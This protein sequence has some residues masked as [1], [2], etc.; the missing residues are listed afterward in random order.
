MTAIPG[1]SAERRY[2]EAVSAL[3]QARWPQAWQIAQGLLREFGEHPGVHFVAGVA[4]LE[5][6]QMQLARAHLARSVEMNGA[7]ADSQTYLAKALAL[8]GDFRA[9]GEAADRALALSPQDPSLLDTLGVVYTEAGR[10]DA[11]ARAFAEVVAKVPERANGRFNHAT[12]LLYAGRIDRAEQEYESC[13]K[14]DECYWKAYTALS[15]LR[16]QQPGRN[17][18]SRLEAMLSRHET[19]PVARTYLHLALAKELEDLGNLVAAFDHYTLGKAAAG[20]G[21]PYSRPTEEALFDALIDA[22]PGPLAGASGHDSDEPL[23]VVGMPRSGTTLVDRI[24]GCHRE[25]VSAGELH[26][27]P[28]AVKRASGSRTSA[29]LD[30][31]TLS[32]TSAIDWSALGHSYLASTRPVTGGTPRF[33]DKL[34]HNFLYIGHILH[35]LPKARI[36][37]MRRHPLDSCLSNF[38]Q[39]F[40]LGSPYTR[41]SFNLLDTGHY[42]V[43]FDRLMRHWASAFPGRVLS[44]NYEDLVLQQE[45]TT[46]ALLDHCGLSWDPACLQFERNQAATA[47]ASVVQVRESMQRGYLG[48]WRQYEPQIAPLR[49]YLQEQGISIE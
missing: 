20:E 28:I 35:A 25:V 29:P 12:A 11:A 48:R 24:L 10:H 41:Y 42:Y 44:L 16:R 14:Q 8:C 22:F 5:L 37:L 43:Q 2:A 36:V 26:Q 40:A 38:R 23:F 9:A 33:V 21:R 39:L 15:N 27:L 32:R 18:I 45:A 30:L 34:P 47:T 3:N 7:R 6:R 46:R 13:L 31:D 17:H 49:A 19:D 1:A 4:A